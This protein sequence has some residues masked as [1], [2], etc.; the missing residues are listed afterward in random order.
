MP[1]INIREQEEVS[2]TAFDATENVVLVPMLYARDYDIDPDTGEII[3][4][5][6][7]VVTKKYTSYKEF[8]EDMASHYLRIDSEDDLDKSYIMA[9]ELLLQGLS[10]VVKPIT[11]NNADYDVRDSEGTII[12]ERLISIDD[13]YKILEE[14]I[15]EGALEEFKDRNLY[16]LKFLTTGG[17]ANCGDVISYPED[18]KEKKIILGSYK[19]LQNLAET[20]GDALAIVEYRQI[21]KTQE[22]LIKEID[23]A[24]PSRFSAGFF[25][26]CV[27]TVTASGVSKETEMPASYCYLSAFA[28]SVK[29]N[30]NWFAA[31]GVSRGR[32]PGIV[33]PL[34][35]VGEALMHVLQGDTK[36]SYTS[37]DPETGQEITVAYLSK[38]LVNPI[39]NA[40]TYGY[41]IW[42]NRVLNNVSEDLYSNFL[43]VRMLLC[44]IK[45]QIYHSAMRVTFEP[46]DDIVWINFKTLVNSTLERMKSGRGISWYKWTKEYA[47]NKA[48]IKATLTIKPIEAVESFDINVVLTD[49]EATVEEAI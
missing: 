32:V 9:Y 13:A 18:Y 20:R 19:V 25:P 11:F 31:A 30:A 8:R 3:Y 42:G 49:E 39:F 36:V 4:N 21:F 46:N 38:V 43:N 5:N 45:K 10:V 22:E 14:K 37:I 1:V 17:Y 40:G 16:N 26:W 28:N 6:V 41:R 35:E 23:K 24:Q 2:F 29:F 15:G 12:V 7:G 33:K 44:D 34:Y 47:E 48:T 27:C